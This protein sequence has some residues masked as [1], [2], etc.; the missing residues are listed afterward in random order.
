MHKLTCLA[1]VSF[2]TALVM[3]STP[4]MVMGA[5]PVAVTTY[6]YDNLRTGWNQHE[7]TLSATS[8]PANFGVLH[9]VALDDQVDAQPLL[10]PGLTIA[11]GTHDVVYVATE[12]NTIYAIDASSGAI[13]LSRNLGT[14]VPTPLGC[15]NNGPN[16]GING[17]PVIDPVAKT[18]YVIAYVEGANGAPPTYQLHALN[19]STLAD[20]PNS[21]LTV[22]ASHTLTNGSTYTF[23]ATYQRQRPAL[24]FNYNT[25][26]A[27]FG[28]FC[29]FHASNSRGWILGWTG[30]TLAPLPANRL[31]DKLGT[32]PSNYFLSSI[33]MSGWGIAATGP[34][35]YVTTGNSDAASY[36]GVNNLQESVIRLDQYLS[37]L[38]V[39]T[40]SNHADLDNGDTDL[41][42]GGVLLLP[43]QSGPITKIAVT[44]GKDGRLFL[45][46]RLSM[47]APIN[48]YSLLGCWCG[49]SYFVGPDGSPRIVTSQGPYIQTWKLSLSPSPNLSQ[50]GTASITNSQDP[51]FFTVVSSNGT[52]NGTGIIWAVSRSTSVNLYAFAAT[53]MNGTYKQ[54]FSSN[55]GSWPNT[56]GNA[57]IVPVV[58]NGKAYVAAYKTLTI[59]GVGG[60]PAVASSTASQPAPVASPD[61]PHLITGTLIAIDRSTLTLQTRTGKSVK[62]DDAQAIRDERVGTP[63]NVGIPLTVQGSLIE[64][65]GALQATSIVRAKGSTG[66]MWPSDR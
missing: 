56:G 35:L 48:T 22:A 53:S 40:P 6:H 63:L 39:F 24:I 47:K 64:G 65:T 19:L 58:A 41:G 52:Q 14:P 36:D 17:T 33:W 38:G 37:L 59:F 66:E 3:G 2:G 31:V 49:P 61:S 16:V 23:N 62:I 28:S 30:G 15:S 54:L 11:G 27:A 25:V 1:L 9:T 12:S 44:A 57:N 20:Q 46:N 60:A 45:L 34:N 29:D 51:G 55:A 10:V 26:Y 13:L 4:P 50:E 42:S 32:S 5:T 18:L 8:F 7:T 43:D 21:P